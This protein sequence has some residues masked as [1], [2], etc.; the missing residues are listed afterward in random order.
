MEVQPC[1]V[2]EPEGRDLLRSGDVAVLVSG[3][4]MIMM[5]ALVMMNRKDHDD[6][7]DDGGGDIVVGC[8]T[9]MIIRLLLFEAV[10]LAV[11]T[12]DC[13]AG[14]ATARRVVGVCLPLTDKF[15][16][17]NLGTTD[18]RG[19]PSCVLHQVVLLCRPSK[20]P[21]PVPKPDPSE[22]DR[23]RK[24]DITRLWSTIL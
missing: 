16:P 17:L 12:A 4:S 15:D 22:S 24:H 1:S 5:V 23:N 11:G 13:M 21:Q 6:D 10:P 9:C 2:H 3:R 7:D 14:Q 18:L 20:K 19:W 8:F